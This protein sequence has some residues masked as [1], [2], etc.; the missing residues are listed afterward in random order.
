[1]N[2]KTIELFLLDGSP[3][4]RV[5]CSISNWD[6]I[7]FKIPKTKLRDCKDRQELKHTGVYFLLNKNDE[8]PS[9]Y[10]GE[11]ENVYERLLQHLNEDTWNEALIFVKKDNNLNKAHVKFLENYFY[12]LGVS[13]DR[14]TLKNS[15]IPTKSSISESDVASMEE[16]AYYIK[17]ITNTLGYKA[18]EKLVETENQE[19]CD[20]FIQSIGLCAK[21]KMTNEGFVVIKGSESSNNFKPASSKSLRRKWEC[22]REENIVDSNGIFIKDYLFSSPSLA[23]SM[24]LGRNANG[25]TEWKNQQKQTLK[26]VLMKDVE[27]NNSLK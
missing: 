14:Y 18:F 13:A 26:E 12:N 3:N 20:Y 23:A 16:F 9:I 21:G 17:M 1:M 6:G 25:L 4:D 7:G 24:I 22:L 11:S 27:K 5:I 2:R 19:D 10:I 8:N 15:N